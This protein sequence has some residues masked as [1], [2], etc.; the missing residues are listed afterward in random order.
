M[1]KVELF[2]VEDAARRLENVVLCS[3][4]GLNETQSREFG[5]SVYFK[6]EDLQQ[7]RSYKIRGAFNKISSLKEN[8]FKNGIVCSWSSSCRHRKIRT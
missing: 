1:Y 3:P 2:A 5:A 7:V 6:R 8:D 4:L